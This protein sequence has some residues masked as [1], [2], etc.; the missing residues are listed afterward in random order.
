VLIGYF[1]GVAI[2]AL[3][4]FLLLVALFRGWEDR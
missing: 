1:V 4:F 3:G 2:E